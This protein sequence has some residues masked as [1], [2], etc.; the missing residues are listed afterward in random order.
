LRKNVNYVFESNVGKKM[1]GSKRDVMYWR[2]GI[3]HKGK[4]TT[5]RGNLVL[6]VRKFIFE[7]GLGCGSDWKDIKCMKDFIIIIIIVVVVVVV[8]IIIIIIIIIYSSFAPH[9]AQGFESASPSEAPVS[10]SWIH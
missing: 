1:S 8:I 5:C 7:M 6:L 3:L 9:G 10:V 2:S 4:V